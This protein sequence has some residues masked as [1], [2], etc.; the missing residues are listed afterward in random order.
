MSDETILVFSGMGFPPGSV[1]GVEE[2]LAPV[3]QDGALRRTVNGELRDFS[4]TAFRK[5]SVQV[6]V[7]AAMNTG[8][9]AFSGVWTGVQ[10]TVDCVTRLIYADTTDGAPE[11]TAVPGSEVVADGFV[12]YRP[13]L[14]MMVVDWTIATD[15]WGAATGWALQLEE[16]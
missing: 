14:T 16:V 7:P 1:R 12:S 10:F 15:E 11:R 9:A 4:D 6:T 5:Y 13:R 8:A 2:Q 3:A